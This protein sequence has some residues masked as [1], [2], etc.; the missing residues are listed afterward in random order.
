MSPGKSSKVAKPVV[1]LDRDGTLN[2]EA[3]YIKNVEDLVLEAGA[4]QAVR[5]LNQAGVSAILVTNQSGPARNYYPQAHVEALHRRLCKLLEKEQAFLDDIY[6]CPHLPAPDGVVPEL[7]KA[8]DCRKPQTGMV[9]RAF[10]EHPELSRGKAFVVGDKATDVELARNVGA[11]A[12]LV[13][14]GYGNA[15]LSGSYQWPVEADYQADSILEAV[16]WILSR[17]DLQ[18]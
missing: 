16:D 15:V 5:K 2:V 9:E 14:T 13:R 18:G 6:Y 1:F 8:C 17:P 4:G 10:R 11:K 7:S 3:G 12:V